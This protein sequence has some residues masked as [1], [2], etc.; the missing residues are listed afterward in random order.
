MNLPANGS[1]EFPVTEEHVFDTQLSVSSLTPDNL[2]TYIRNKAISDNARRQLQQIADVKTQIANTDTEKR[3]VTD[4]ENAV[5]RDEERN[6][7]NIASLSTV[8]GQQQIVQD[9][10]RKLSD[11]E[12]QIA[13]LR[14]RGTALDQQHAALQA[15]LNG[16]IEKLDF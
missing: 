5:T 1:L 11:Q 15:Q 8:S 6:R 10:A 16:L 3:S 12:T 2:L 14:D 7:Q 4:Q 9:Y 13:K